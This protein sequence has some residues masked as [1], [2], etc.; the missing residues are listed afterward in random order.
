VAAPFKFL[1]VR[2]FEG[3]TPEEKRAYLVEATAEQQRTK[4]DPAE[5]GWHRLFREDQDQTQQQEPQLKDDTKP[6]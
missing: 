6:D 2:E 1:S 3:L 5:G 4:A